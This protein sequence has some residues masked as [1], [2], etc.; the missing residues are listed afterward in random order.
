MEEDVVGCFIAFLTKYTPIWVETKI[1]QSPL[2]L[3]HRENVIVC[4]CPYEE[5]SLLWDFRFP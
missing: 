3:F 4:S 1:F 2:Y 5:F